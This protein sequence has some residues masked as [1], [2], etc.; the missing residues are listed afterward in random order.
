MTDKDRLRRR[1]SLP[2][3]CKSLIDVVMPFPAAGCAVGATLTH[4]YRYLNT[5]NIYSVS[6]KDR[7]KIHS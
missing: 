1:A 2:L 5:W 4:E 3:A 7:K 6:E